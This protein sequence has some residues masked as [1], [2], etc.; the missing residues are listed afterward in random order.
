M[1]RRQFMQTICIASVGILS[2]CK[3]TPKSTSKYSNALNKN[4]KLF[5][6]L[7]EFEHKSTVKVS[8]KKTAIALS[9]TS[10]DNYT[11][12]LLTCTHRGCV[13]DI[14]DAKND[15][16]GVDFICPCHGAKFSTNGHVIK[17]PAQKNLTQFTVTSNREFVIVHLP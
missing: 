6:A 13:V 5:I 17:G 1:H 8:Y 10:I 15:I 12:V 7:A 11:A 4:N 3:S 2:G 9:K 16:N 14:S